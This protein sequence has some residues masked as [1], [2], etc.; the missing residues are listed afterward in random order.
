MPYQ[1]KNNRT[2]EAMHERRIAFGAYIET[3]LL[4]LLS[5]LDWRDW[6]LSDWTGAMHHSI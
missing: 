2:K 4:L 1:L 3:Y 5:W 6:I